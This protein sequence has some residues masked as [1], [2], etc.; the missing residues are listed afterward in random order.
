MIMSASEVRR[1]PQ[2][3]LVGEKNFEGV[4]DFTYLGALINN[5]NY[6]SQSAR[7]RIQAENWP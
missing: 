7:Q 6:M 2:T 5:R 1:R 4:P 3:L